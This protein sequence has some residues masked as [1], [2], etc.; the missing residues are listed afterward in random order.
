MLREARRSRVLS[1]GGL[2]ALVAGALGGTVSGLG[3]GIPG[4]LLGA[5]GGVIPALAQGLL[6]R[7]AAEPGFVRRHYL[8]FDRPASNQDPAA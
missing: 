7:R 1:R 6:D 4:G 8:V 2:V 3:G 5:A